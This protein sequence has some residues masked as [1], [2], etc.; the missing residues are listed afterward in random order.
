MNEE[1]IY[2]PQMEKNTPFWIELAGTSYCDGSYRIDRRNSKC[3]VAEY[4]LSGRG[5]VVFQ[6]QE[7]SVGAGDMYVLPAGQD[8]LY[9][10]D[11]EEPLVK[12]WFNA[13]G[14][15]ANSLFEVYDPQLMAVFPGA[16]GEEY[17]RRIHSLG[18]EEHISAEGKQNQA[19]VIF[20]ELMQYLHN[21][22][23]GSGRQECREIA[24]LKEYIANH[25]TENLSL[26]E[27]AELVY[28]SESQVIRIFKRDLGITPYEYI[29]YPKMQQAKLMLRRTGLM[30][31]EI[32]YQLGF[33]DE[34][35]FTYLFKQRVGKT[36]TAYRRESKER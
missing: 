21:H 28:L 6:G 17:I 7:Y 11:S 36:P 20:L 3:M 13:R 26:R 19:A 9:Y 35:Y 2:F 14:A 33:T 15:F 18:K 23:Y 32:A 1:F 8:Q 34:H 24:L 4:V 22:Y 5:T 10:S 27:L 25:L 16:Q 29:L 30:V 12:I 31:K